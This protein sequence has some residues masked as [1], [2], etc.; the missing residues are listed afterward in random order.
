MILGLIAPTAGTVTVLGERVTVTRT[1]ALRRVGALVGSPAFVPFLS[2]RQ[3]LAHMAR[4]HSGVPSGRVEAALARLGLL[5]AA[6]RPAGRY[7]SGMKQRLGLALALLH[8]PELLILDEPTNGLD[9]AG[10]LEVRTLL[11]ELA[12]QGVT[13]MLS[14]HL[15]HE[16]E[17]VCDELL[18]LH[19]GRVVAQGAVSDL[20]VRQA[21]TR[22][23]L[24]DP[25]SAVRALQSLPGRGEVRLQGDW[26]SVSGVGGQAVVAHLA[27]HGLIP[28][29]VTGGRPDLEG[30]FIELTQ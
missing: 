8:A 14:S 22:V 10:M 16:V 9:P 30:L 4:L 11:R 23:R 1:A 29:E 13:V 15:L 27:A 20:L 17:Q 19:H 7:S 25:A 5:D 26:V 18:V 28:S 21:S 3:N 12:G 2:A 6:D 24:D